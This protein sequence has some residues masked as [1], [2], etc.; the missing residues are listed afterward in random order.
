MNEGESPH[1]HLVAITGKHLPN[2]HVRIILEHK[3][4]AWEDTMSFPG[5]DDDRHFWLVLKSTYFLQ[6]LHKAGEDQWTDKES[7]L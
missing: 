7:L 5:P 1:H 3:I 2:H 6:I 4:F